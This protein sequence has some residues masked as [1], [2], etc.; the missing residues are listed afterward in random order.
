MAK[1]NAKPGRSKASLGKE[2]AA[3]KTSKRASPLA[4]PRRRSGLEAAPIANPELRFVLEL[5]PGRDPA[6]IRRRLD[7][8]VPQ[9]FRFGPLFAGGL[10]E[11]P[12]QS[13][14]NIY[15]LRLLGVDEQ[16]T[17]Q[18]PFDLGDKIAQVP[19]VVRAEPDLETDFF[20]TPEAAF[21][22]C[23]V[24]GAPPRDRAWALRKLRV[25]EAWALAPSKG[26]GVLIA[27]IDTGVT[28]HPELAGA[29]DIA[30]GADLIEGDADPTDPL[31]QGLFLNP[32][33][34][35]ATASV[36]VSRGDVV[37]HQPGSGSSG[38]T[39]G[40]VT[41]SAPGASLVPI[42]AI[43][44]VVRITQSRVAQAI[45]HARRKECHVIT[46][47]LGGLPSFALWRAVEAAVKANMLVLAAAGNCV[48][49]VVYPAAYD[50]CVAVGG[51]NQNDAIWIGSC[52]GPEVDVS[53]PAEGIWRAQRQ[54]PDDPPDKAGG[55]GEGT[56]YAV[57]IT[58]GVAALW[59]S[60][61]GRDHLIQ[62]ARSKG[63]TLQ[64]LLMQLIKASARRPPGWDGAKF[65]A[66]IVDAEALLN[67]DPAQLAPVPE[68]VEAVAEQEPSGEELVA[69]AL[70]PRG[71]EI[72]VAETV[73]ADL[74]ALA[75]HA[76]EITWLALKARSSAGKKRRRRPEVS[77]GLAEVLADPQ[78]AP[79]S[80]QLG[81][82]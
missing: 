74:R 42:R 68:A 22:G 11:V 13:L 44:S 12:V 71:D 19:G 64:A 32:G 41:G 20:P 27:Q 81:M 62:I 53:A 36:A 60:H 1:A 37:S 65:G 75:P 50:L 80:R 14:K 55:D 40:K 26:A 3:R 39:G 78:N 30:R 4:K 10:T 38:T 8:I 29:L 16:T 15:L 63:L 5:E 24:N 21:P 43:R 82:S 54:K 67:A 28:L 51:I 6:D 59:L 73:P 34:G 25:P 35:T 72:G 9:P 17:T 23:W 69:K 49:E 47:S 18:N 77:R 45:E 61:H 31:Q 7:V 2:G 48:R 79:V 33:H 76:L 66:G 46:M 58:A 56:S 57:A 52:R 70:M